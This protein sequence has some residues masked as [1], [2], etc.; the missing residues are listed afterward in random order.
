MKV[1][2]I[3]TRIVSI[4]DVLTFQTTSIN[5][6][7]SLQPHLDSTSN[8]GIRPVHPHVESPYVE[9]AELNVASWT[10]AVDDG[11]AYFLENGTP[12]IPI[13]K[14]SQEGPK[15]LACEYP[16]MKG[17]KSC[18]GPNSRDCWLANKNKVIGIN[19][20]YE[21]VKEIPVGITRKVSVCL[22]AS[23]HLT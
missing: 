22:H 15:G 20:D 23:S 14:N 21:N 18:H 16:D 17:Y 1:T 10:D 19:T 9:S 5:K 11:K 7:P 6:Q 8:H 3:W 13:S 4:F 2:S 12:L